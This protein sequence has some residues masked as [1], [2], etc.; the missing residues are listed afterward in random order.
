M[1]SVEYSEAIVEILDILNN[2][3][4][5]IYNKIPKKLIEFWQQNKSETY[6]PNLDHSKKLTEMNLKEKTKAIIA[7][8]Y[9]NYLCDEDE[10]KETILIL[11]NNENA[12]Q[13]E[14]REKYNPDNIFK[15]TNKD[16]MAEQNIN[17]TDMVKYKK[18]IILRIIDFIKRFLKK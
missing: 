16:V 10:K 17:I 18:S 6:K 5:T 12:Y 2:S 13:K 4:E 15:N 7:M 9:L 11:K 14:I 1:V 3:D 8:I